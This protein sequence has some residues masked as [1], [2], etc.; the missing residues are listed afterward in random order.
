MKS[1]SKLPRAAVLAIAPALCA[2]APARAADV[3]ASDRAGVSQ[4]LM[5]QF[6]RPDARLTVDPVVVAGDAALAGWSQ[7]ERGGR[8]LLFRTGHGW[9]IALCGGDGLKDAKVLREAGVKGAAADTL[10]RQLAA[11]EARLPAAHRARFSTF[12]GLLRMDASGAHPPAHK[13]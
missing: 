2:V 13:H 5:S 12:D 6:D 4:V 1:L 7:G 9:Q 8:A 3:S 11:A 10:A